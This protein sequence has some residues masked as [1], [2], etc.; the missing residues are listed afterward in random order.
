M[1]RGRIP[2]EAPMRR[3]LEHIFTAVLFGDVQAGPG[4]G[5]AWAFLCR[6]QRVRLG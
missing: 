1:R 5:P 4:G 6:A 3:S 2:G